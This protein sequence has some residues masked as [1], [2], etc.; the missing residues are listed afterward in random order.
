VEPKR[1]VVVANELDGMD[2]LAV[3]EE[4]RIIK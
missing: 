4:G 2:L 3:A 1:V